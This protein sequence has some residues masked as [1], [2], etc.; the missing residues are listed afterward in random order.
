M[1]VLFL[2]HTLELVVNKNN[3]TTYRN[4]SSFK[5]NHKSAS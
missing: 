2:K 1:D 3:R 4:V 5:G